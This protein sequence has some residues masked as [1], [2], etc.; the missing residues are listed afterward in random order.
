M[1]D[2]TPTTWAAAL[3]TRLG[4]PV[5][6]SNVTAITA[7][8]TAEG[9]NWHNPDRYN[10][11]NT[12]QPATGAVST[13]GAGVKAY[14][15]WDQGLTATAQTLTNGLYGGILSALSKG[16]S[17]DDVVSAV[18]RSPWG[19]KNIA[20]SGSASAAAGST[21]QDAIHIPTP[22]DLTSLPGA[23]SNLAL[24]LLFVGGGALIVVLGLV[25][26]TTVGRRASDAYGA[27]LKDGAKLAAE[28]A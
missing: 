13:N 4:V 16:S 9:G 28:V 7:W 15:S 10:P 12:T 17:A 22:G 11:L 8:E 27:H 21:A 23:A 25:R 18:T 1:T 3:L 24:K 5:T 26:G 19:T 2:Y 20:L 6:S 14:T